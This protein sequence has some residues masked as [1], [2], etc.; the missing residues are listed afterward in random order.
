MKPTQSDPQI[1][2]PTRP[3]FTAIPPV[4]AAIDVLIDAGRYHDALLTMMVGVHNH[5]KTP[6]VEH[7]CLYYPGLDRQV[8]RLAEV[9]E[10][11][12]PDPLGERPLTRNTLIVATEVGQVGGHARVLLDLMREVSSPVL[13]LTEAFANHRAGV[14]DNAW[15]FEA[16]ADASVIVLP[17]QLDLWAKGR[18][19]LKL[20]QRLAPRNIFYFNHHQDALPL[21]G[22]I[23]HPRSRKAFVHHADHNPS[24]GVTLP[25]LDHLD[26]TDELAAVCG[27]AL[28]TPATVL[29]LHVPDAGRRAFA[30]LQGDDCSVVTSGSPV[31]FAREGD[32]ALHAIVR[33]VLA[34]GRGR[35]F[36]IGPMDAPWHAQIVAHLAGHGLDPSRFVALGSVPSLWDT[37]RDLPAHV[38]IGSA[39]VGG[40]RAAIEAQGCGYPLAYYRPTDPDSLVAMDSI[41][42]DPA[43]G[44]STADELVTVL[45]RIGTD[46]TRHTDA[47]RRMYEDRFSRLHFRRVLQALGAI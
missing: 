11:A 13:V 30:P 21:V 16:C 15:L 19:L 35:F 41:Y 2:A 47:A 9:L 23:G 22:T 17:P 20:T 43:L 42:A 37:L 26:V 33:A 44:W 28:G 39:P 7:T 36:H 34:A 24:L 32:L 18:A 38:Y 27:R 45:Q 8:L 3:E 46:H 10:A 31:K 40:A 29:P 4:E 6:G 25:G 1:A 5:Y 14:N 12:N